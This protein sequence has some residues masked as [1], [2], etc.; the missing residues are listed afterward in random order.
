MCKLHQS[1]IS[2]RDCHY[3]KLMRCLRRTGQPALMHL[4]GRSTRPKEEG[5]LQRGGQGTTANRRSSSI[6]GDAAPGM[7][8]SAA[9]H[10]TGERG[11]VGASG[12]NAAAPAISAT[13]AGHVGT[14]GRRGGRTHFMVCG[15]CNN[16]WRC[17]GAAVQLS[18]REGGEARVH[19]ALALRRRLLQRRRRRARRLCNYRR[20][21]E[22]R[23]AGAMPPG[24]DLVPLLQIWQ[25]LYRRRAAPY[26]SCLFCVL[27]TATAKPGCWAGWL[28]SA[29]HLAGEAVLLRQSAAGQA[30][31]M[32][33][34]PRCQPSSQGAAHD[35]GWCQSSKGSAPAQAVQL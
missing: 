10:M 33:H 13:T 7:V 18:G 24:M 1:R 35:S 22:A 32:P 9:G 17:A 20:A 11:R 25:R 29:V 26:R 23:L 34:A 16:T 2:V 19:G 8:A 21:P 4:H 31:H 3:S 30:W 14:R 5:Q 15:C 12:G 28:P 6:S 27:Y